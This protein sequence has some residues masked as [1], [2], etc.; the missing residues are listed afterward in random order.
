MLSLPKHCGILLDV[1]VLD[2]IIVG[3]NRYYSFSDEGTM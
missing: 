3:D 2:H 1:A